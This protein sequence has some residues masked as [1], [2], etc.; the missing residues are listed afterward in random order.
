[1]ATTRDIKCPTCG[2]PAGK[3]CISVKAGKPIA[4]MH[5]SR[6]RDLIS[7]NE[8]VRRGVQ[9]LRKPVWANRFDHLKIDII[10]GQIGPW[11]HLYAPFNT[12]CNGRDP[13]NMLAFE[14]QASFD[15]Q[16]FAIYDGPLP[17]SEEYRAEVASFA[18][19]VERT[20]AA[21]TQ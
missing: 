15:T 11:L 4:D 7:I 18:R 6:S 5:R 16:E 20:D 10:D 1:M 14:H 12:Q 8:A 17:E 3:A 21:L 9:R 2:V 13:V 19:L